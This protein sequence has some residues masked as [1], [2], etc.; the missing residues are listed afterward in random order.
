MKP[1]PRL[2][3]EIK[4]QGKYTVVSVD[5][6]S[7]SEF[8]MDKIKRESW[9]VKMFTVYIDSKQISCLRVT[10]FLGNET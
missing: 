6:K 3:H 9:S 8:S 5:S 1:G 10:T 2:L 4:C 7:G